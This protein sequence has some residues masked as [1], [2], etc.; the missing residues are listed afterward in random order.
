MV[1]ITNYYMEIE[2]CKACPMRE[3]YTNYGESWDYCSAPDF[4]DSPKGYDD[5]IPITN[6]GIDVSSFP[7]WC[8][9]PIT[10]TRKI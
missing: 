5:I 9:L 3:N 1:S 6:K 7:E 2:K 8:P 10:I 4:S